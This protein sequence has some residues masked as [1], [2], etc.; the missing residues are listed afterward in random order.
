MR[1]RKTEMSKRCQKLISSY[2]HKIPTGWLNLRPMHTEWKL[3]KVKI[4]WYIV[5]C[6]VDSQTLD[7]RSSLH[8]LFFLDR[9]GIPGV[10]L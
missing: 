6:H 9:N 2:Q 8:I 3:S 10:R 7:T 1:F 4:C 5:V